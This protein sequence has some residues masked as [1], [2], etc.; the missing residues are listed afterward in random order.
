MREPAKYYAAYLEGAFDTPREAL[1]WIASKTG[2]TVVE[3]DAAM[4]WS[5]HTHPF[6]ALIP[7]DEEHGWVLIQTRGEKALLWRAFVDDMGAREEAAQLIEDLKN[8]GIE[9]TFGIFQYFPP[10]QGRPS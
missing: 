3:V 7:G 2:W 1:N 10:E 5:S 9:G 4:A 6:T 8:E